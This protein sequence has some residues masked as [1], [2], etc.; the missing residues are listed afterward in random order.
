M[1]LFGDSKQE[2]LDKLAKSIFDEMN[3]LSQILD[4]NNGMLNSSGRARAERIESLI[5]DFCLLCQRYQATHNYVSWMGRK[6][7]INSVLMAITGF[8]GEVTQS[9]GHQFTKLQ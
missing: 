7:L 9:S 8:L 1:G 6:T 5:V 2:G 3:L 4:T